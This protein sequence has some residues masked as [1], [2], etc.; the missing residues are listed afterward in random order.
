MV[1]PFVSAP[2][3]VSV[4]P[5]MGDCFQV[6]SGP[7]QYRGSLPAESPDTRKDPHRIPQ[8]I[9]RPLVSG[10]FQTC[11]Q[12]SF[13]KQ[14]HSGIFLNFYSFLV[15]F[16]F[17]SESWQCTQNG[18]GLRDWGSLKV[19]L[20]KGTGW[21]EADRWGKMCETFLHGL[22]A[23]RPGYFVCYLTFKELPVLHMKSC[24]PVIGYQKCEWKIGLMW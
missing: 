22:R 19:G 21:E 11:K 23:R 10:K 13:V 6:P 18:L 2:N 20:R 16:C 4:T 9:L 12:F 15:L 8:G 1:H 17:L 24:V 3:F 7:L 5:S 14:R